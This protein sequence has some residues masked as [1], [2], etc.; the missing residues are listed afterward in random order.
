MAKNG[1][2]API[3]IDAASASP[4]TK[5]S[6]YPEPFASR[7]A[8]RTKRPLGDVFALANF[9]VNLTQLEPGGESAL[10][11]GHDKQDEFIYVLLGEPTLVMEDSETRLNPGMCAGFL[12]G[13][14]AHHLVN[15]TDEDVYFLEVGDRP[16]GDAVHYPNDDIKAVMGDDGKWVYTHKNDEPY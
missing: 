12:A 15:R 5:P 3:A 1:A 4:R 11:H 16:I 8:K 13:G 7:M 14:P 6:N 10:M 2:Q 9:G